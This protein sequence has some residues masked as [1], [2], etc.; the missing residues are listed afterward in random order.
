MNSL[1]ATQMPVLWLL[2]SVNLCEYKVSEYGVYIHIL[3][4]CVYKAGIK[5]V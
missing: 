5:R 3:I 2:K 1:H 4:H